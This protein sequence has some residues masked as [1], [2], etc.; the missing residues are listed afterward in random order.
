MGGKIGIDS[1]PG[2]GSTF[3]FTASF[4]LPRQSGESR[5]PGRSP[6]VTVSCPIPDPEIPPGLNILLVEDDLINRSLCK[7]L[8]EE[9]RVHVSIAK[10]GLEAVDA[11]RK[12]EFDLVLMDIQMPKMSGFEATKKIRAMEQECNRQAVPIIAITA[13]AIEGYGKR[14]LDAGMDDYITKPLEPDDI[15]T[16]I[17]RQLASRGKVRSC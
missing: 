5:L 15:Y 2:K 13:H 12:V 6:G 17:K 9:K 1:Q 14:C 3:W 11:A 4:S 10:D 8:L 16:A 7:T